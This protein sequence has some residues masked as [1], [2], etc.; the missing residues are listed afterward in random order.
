MSLIDDALKRAREE[1]ARQDEAHR[2]TKRPWI[3]PEP[4][5][6]RGGRAVFVAAALGIG[7]GGGVAALLMA[8]LVF[9]LAAA[10]SLLAAGA[11]IPQ[12][13]WA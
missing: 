7:A 9:A 11:V 12:S 5:K 10:G 6:I 13:R 2:R 8:A 4:P 3:P 1:A